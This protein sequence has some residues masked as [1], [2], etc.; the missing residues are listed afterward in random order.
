MK[1]IDFAVVELRAYS[2]IKWDLIKLWAAGLENG[3]WSLVQ[4]ELEDMVTMSCD[5]E[6][7]PLYRELFFLYRLSVIL[8][9]EAN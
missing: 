4:A 6:S 9:E 3:E 2:D 8:S 7:D 1:G 5:S